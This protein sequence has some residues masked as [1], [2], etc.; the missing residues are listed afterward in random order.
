MVRLTDLPSG[1]LSSCL[2]PA[3]NRNPSSVSPRYVQT[4]LLTVVEC[5]RVFAWSEALAIQVYYWRTAQHSISAQHR[6]STA[7]CTAQ[8]STATQHSTRTATAQAQHSTGT[9]TAQ[10]RRQH[11]T[12]QRQNENSTAQHS[13]AQHIHST[14]QQQ[15]S[16]TPHSAQHRHSTW[17]KGT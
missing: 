6:H 1:A 11:S 2:H 16:T 3:L 8:H 17:T 4:R 9:G 10:H 5:V 14:A 12:A 13:T 7:Q 15:H